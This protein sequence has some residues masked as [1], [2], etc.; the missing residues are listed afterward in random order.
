VGE[1]DVAGAGAG[2]AAGVGAGA[3]AGAGAGVGV[4]V[5]AG[6]LAAVQRFVADAVRAGAPA[7]EDPARAARVEALVVASARG[8]RPA[9]RLEVYREQFWLRHLASLEDDYPTLAWAL[10][11]SEALRALATEYLAACPPRTWDLQKL[12][13]DMPA[14]VAAHARWGSH[15]LA[16][17]AARL[18]WAFMEGFDAPDAPP[19]DPRV[20]ASTPEDAWSGA[21]IV[22]HPS[23]RLLRLAHP[24]HEVRDALKRGE[25]PAR[26]LALRETH[27]VV[28]REPS[29]WLRSAPVEALAFDLLATLQAG[30]PLG[31]ACAAVA[32]AAG[33]GDPG[34]AAATLEAQLGGW[35]QQW[36]A[37]AWIASVHFGG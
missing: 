32:G 18:D 23:V 10:G 5:G 31:E 9:E 37:S 34:G 3:A 20:L 22:L 4:G 21:R 28:W 1:R 36:T 29:C 25:S 12:G 35:F 8:M 16:R 14:F 33:D 2:A 27:V 17:D 13:A 7:G 24:V 11:G 15:V 26:A 6:D 19:F 30:T